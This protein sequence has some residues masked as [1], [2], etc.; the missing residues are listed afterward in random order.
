MPVPWA[1]PSS[2]A[3]LNDEIIRLTRI[4]ETGSGTLTLD[5]GYAPNLAKSGLKAFCWR[6][7]TKCVGKQVYSCVA[8]IQGFR[9]SALHR[10]SELHKKGVRKLKLHKKSGWN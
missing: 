3:D 6:N 1:A 2:F 9:G 5:T 10:K 7:P 8:G 4:A